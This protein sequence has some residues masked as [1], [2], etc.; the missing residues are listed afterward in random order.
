MTATHWT[1]AHTLQRRGITTHALIKVSGLSKGTVYDI[2]NG[3]S[4]GVT[5]ETV[6]KLLDGLEQL[7]GQRMTI[8]AVLDRTESIN[9]QDTA[10]LA[11]ITDL[12]PFDLEA[13]KATVPNWTPEEQEENSR[14]WLAHEDDRKSRSNHRQQ[15]LDVLWDELDV[16]D[17]DACNEEESV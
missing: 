7:T 11:Q 6:D 1:L 15:K 8:D 10:L 9:L 3:K 12:P 5:L 16:N 17:A 2:V 4:Q 14:L 13:V